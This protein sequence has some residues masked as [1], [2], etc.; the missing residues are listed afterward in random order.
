[1]TISYVLFKSEINLS[2]TESLQAM[3]SG[4]DWASCKAVKTGYCLIGQITLVSCKAC[5]HLSVSLL[6]SEMIL[7]SK[8]RTLTWKNLPPY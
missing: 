8:A 2:K 3:C 4:M 5:S 1:M 6:L 7:I